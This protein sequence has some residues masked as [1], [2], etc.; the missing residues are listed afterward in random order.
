MNMENEHFAP[1]EGGRPEYL[2]DDDILTLLKENCIERMMTRKELGSNGYN[3]LARKDVLSVLELDWI[4][5][6]A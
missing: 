1:S 4:L 5:K 6:L 2:I 3:I